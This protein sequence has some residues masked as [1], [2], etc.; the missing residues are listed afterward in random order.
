MANP[1]FEPRPRGYA[2]LM[3][4]S[5]VDYHIITPHNFTTTLEFLG[6]AGAPI[7][8]IQRR[9]CCGVRGGSGGCVAVWDAAKGVCLGNGG[10][11]VA[12]GG[13]TVLLK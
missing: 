2:L 7:S 4:A 5:E 8:G 6:G 13:E 10:Y 9:T 11:I 12:R 1:I 3:N